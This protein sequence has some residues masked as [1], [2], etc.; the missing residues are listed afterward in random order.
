MIFIKSTCILALAL[1]AVVE[2]QNFSTAASNKIYAQQIVYDL[3]AA[4]C[5]LVVVGLHGATPTDLAKNASAAGTTI[6]IN[7]DRIGKPD[8]VDD[9]AVAIDHKTVMAPNP[10]D[11]TKFE[12]ATP[13]LT[14]G[15]TMLNASINMVFD[16]RMGRK[17]D[18]LLN[19]FT[20]ANSYVAEVSK[21]VPSWEAMFAPV[22][23]LT[24]KNCPLS[25]PPPFSFCF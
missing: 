11:N 16:Y 5:D 19:M 25:S 1:P 20:R 9:D 21:K 24:I 22:S 23:S 10:T 3:L 14:M 4:H 17:G 2:A 7:L 13:I 15:G 6:A 12:I 18:D 8:D